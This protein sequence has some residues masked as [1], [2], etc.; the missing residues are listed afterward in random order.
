VPSTL[1]RR[2]EAAV[3][4]VLEQ[5]NGTLVM[6]VQQALD[7]QLAQLVET[8]LDLRATNDASATV[9]AEPDVRR[10]RR[11]HQDKPPSAYESARRV[12]RSCRQQQQR[13]RERHAAAVRDEGPRPGANA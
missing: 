7:R 12:C 8:E 11:C 3:A 5:R 2:V 9:Q 1:E 10:C 6:L 13:D 4:A